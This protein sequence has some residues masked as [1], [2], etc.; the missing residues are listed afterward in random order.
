MWRNKCSII[1]KESKKKQNRDRRWI[2]HGPV[3]TLMTNPR[4]NLKSSMQGLF[5]K[6]WAK[7][8]GLP[9]TREGEAPIKKSRKALGLK[10]QGGKWCQN[11]RRAVTEAEEPPT[12]SRPLMESSSRSMRWNPPS[13]GTKVTCRAKGRKRSSQRLRSSEEE[14]K[15]VGESLLRLPLACGAVSAEVLQEQTWASTQGWGFLLRQRSQED[16]GAH[17]QGGAGLQFHLPGQ[18]PVFCRFQWQPGRMSHGRLA[19]TA[20]QV[21]KKES[22]PDDTLPTWQESQACQP[23]DSLSL[24][25]PHL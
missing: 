24:R 23:G 8:R 14:R 10:E 5:T 9:D 12:R 6:I 21:R 11:S 1:V 19:P 13:R 25:V 4:S 2:S 15:E 17:Q 3:R 22:P 20:V 7:W 16:R 18:L